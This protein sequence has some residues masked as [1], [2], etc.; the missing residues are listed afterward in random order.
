MKN[1]IKI[2]CLLILFLNPNVSEAQKKGSKDKGKGK[3]TTSLPTKYSDSDFKTLAYKSSKNTVDDDISRGRYANLAR[4]NYK[5]YIKNRDE[6]L[7]KPKSEQSK[8]V[9][10][11]IKKLDDFY[12]TRAE[13]M[14]PD[15]ISI[16]EDRTTKKVEKYR[17]DNADD[18]L[19]VLAGKGMEVLGTALDI[20]PDNEKL[21]AKK[22]EHDALV[23]SIQEYIDSGAFAKHVKEKEFAERSTFATDYK[24]GKLST[25]ENRKKALTGIQNYAEEADLQEKFLKA[26]VKDDEWS[27]EKNAYGVI[28]NRH[29]LVYFYGTKKDGNCFV[30]CFKMKQDFISGNKY[31]S[32]F[33]FRAYI[34]SLEEAHCE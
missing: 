18:A 5:L 1:L 29:I 31:K 19:K 24:E 10:D 34:G 16:Y 12:A 17:V 14:V 7:S 15:F 22:K 11:A 8:E 20:F 21:L 9:S 28:L 33:S 2:S 3:I 4:F 23:K 26:K 30:R 27:Y 13:T 6:Y 32:S 25:V